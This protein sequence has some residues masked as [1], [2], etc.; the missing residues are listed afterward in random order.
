M[1]LEEEN[2]I[3]VTVT[4]SSTRGGTRRQPQQPGY[5]HL[6]TYVSR[7]TYHDIQR[8]SKEKKESM[9]SIVAKIVNAHYGK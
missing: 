2:V 4:T 7:E 5:K 6:A 9:S 3:S 1:E 8:D